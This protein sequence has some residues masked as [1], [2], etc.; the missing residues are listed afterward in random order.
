[1][2]PTKSAAQAET[3][4]VAAGTAR[5][6]DKSFPDFVKREGPKFKRGERVWFV[7]DAQG[8]PIRT[9]ESGA[10]AQGWIKRSANRGKGY[11]TDFFQN[12]WSK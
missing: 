5:R 2:E 4:H 12:L 7:K 9:F 8:N 11:T 1:M 6:A 3:R 10:Q